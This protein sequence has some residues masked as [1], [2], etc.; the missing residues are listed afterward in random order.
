V[1]ETDAPWLASEP[2]RGRTNE[3]AHVIHTARKLA[4]LRGETL[5]ETAALTTANACHLFGLDPSGLTMD[6]PPPEE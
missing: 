2:L 3:P 4:E 6:R 1:I 5:A